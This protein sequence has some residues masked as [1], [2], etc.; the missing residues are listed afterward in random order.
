[1]DVDTV[2]QNHTYKLGDEFYLQTE[3]A[4]IGLQMSG[5][6]GR[7]C[8]MVWDRLYKQELIK[9]EI[10]M[11]MFGRFVDDG[12]MYYKVPV[13]VDDEDGVEVFKDRLL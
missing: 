11:Q 10:K 4:P 7:L 9:N 8:C 2:M 13:P 5:E 3:G 1:M 6:I 12:K